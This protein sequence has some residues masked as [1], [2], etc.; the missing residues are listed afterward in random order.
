MPGLTYLFAYDSSL[1]CLCPGSLRYRPADHLRGPG[2]DAE[3]PAGLALPGALHSAHQ[4]HCSA[5]PQGAAPVLDRKW[6]CGEYQFD[7]TAYCRR[8]KKRLKQKDNKK[9]LELNNKQSK[10]EFQVE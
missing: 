4:P 10:V 5:V 2:R 9:N 8:T 1:F 7:M 3:G 6:I